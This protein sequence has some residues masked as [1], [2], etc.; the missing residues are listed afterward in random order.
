MLSHPTFIACDVR[1]NAQ[2]KTFLTKQRIA[3]VARTIRPDLTS[4]R[5]MDNVLFLITGPHH[6]F[7]AW[8]QR[9][10]HRV[11]ARHNTFFGLVDFRVDGFA[12]TRHDA[13]IHHDVRRIS[14][15]HADLCHGRINGSHAVRQHIHGATLHAAIEQFFQLAPHGKRGHPIVSGASAIFRKRADESA[16]FHS[17]N[18]VSIGAG[19]VTTRPQILIELDESAAIDELFAERIVFLLRTIYPMNC[20]GL[21]ELG[22]FFHPAEQMI[23]FAERLIGFVACHREVF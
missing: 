7:R 8:R 10:A 11:H 12:D 23:I 15:L 9:H 18:I 6:V 14:Q 22:H 21:C 5:K 1:C 17:S 3:A 16:V 20:G 13:H 19:V 2:G 4:F